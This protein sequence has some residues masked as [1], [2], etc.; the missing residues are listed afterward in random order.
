VIKSSARFVPPPARSAVRDIVVRARHAGLR[1][2]DA[3]V[4]SYPKSGSTWVR[5]VLAA[6][7]SGSEMDFDLVR[8]YVP[9]VGWHRRG[10]ALLPQG[11]RLVKSHEP[12]RRLTLGAATRVIYL[13]RDGRD[14]AV[15]YFH[16]QR[17]IGA[18]WP[19]IDAFAAAFLDGQVGSY[20]AWQNHVAG[21]LAQRDRHPKRVAVVRYEDMLVS[22]VD[23]LMEVGERLSLGLRAEALAAAVA[24]N[25]ATEMRAKEASSR[26]LDTG[27]RD[28]HFVRA[29][30]AG[31]WDQA[32]SAATVLRFER[33]AGA[34]LRGAGYPV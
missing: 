31:Q 19:E 23:T 6:A 13:V 32:L 20:G 15:S 14:V 17:R 22:P 18:A 2:Q 34:A 29:A 30:S 27:V 26:I 33:D 28:Q 25:T 8:E 16:H 11:G 1:S 5:F 21:W 7:L 10:P 24:A 12:Y 3:A 4:V 9:P